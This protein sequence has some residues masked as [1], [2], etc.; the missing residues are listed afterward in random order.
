[1]FS[2]PL[3]LTAPWGVWFIGIWW[4]WVLV[5]VGSLPSPSLPIGAFGLGVEVWFGWGENTSIA[6]RLVLGRGI[7]KGY[8]NPFYLLKKKSSP[9]T[10][11]S[12]NSKEYITVASSRYKN[13][14]TFSLVVLFIVRWVLN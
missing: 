5:G 10:D 6:L 3:P 11:G 9:I 13:S 1:M 12:Q 14:T 8:F 4:R 2:S 7:K